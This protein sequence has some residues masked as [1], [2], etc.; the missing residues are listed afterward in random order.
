VNEH[1]IGGSLTAKSG[2][3]RGKAGVASTAHPLA[4][5]AALDVLAKGGNAVDAAIAAHAVICVVMPHAAGL[6]GDLLMLV[7]E[8]AGGL[9]AVNGTGS[10]GS[11]WSPP[12][13]GPG[14]SVTVPGIAAG[15]FAAHSRG[16]SLP[17]RQILEAAHRIAIDGYVV[18][19]SLAQARD[20]QRQRFES[21]GCQSWS[22][23][24][25]SVGQLWKQPELGDLFDNLRNH[26]AMNFYEADV[27]EAVARA[28]APFGGN[29]TAADFQDHTCVTQDAVSTKWGTG[30]I[31]VQPPAS[32]GLLLAMAARWVESHSE[33]FSKPGITGDPSTNAASDHLLVEVTGAVFAHRDDVVLCATSLL[34]EELV[35]DTVTASHRGGPRSYL[36]TAGVAVTDASGMTVS[37]LVSVFDDFGAAIHVPELGIVLNNRADG[38]TTGSNSY[39]PNTYPIHTLAPAIV[40][41]NTGHSLALATPGADG[42][43]QTLIQVLTRMRFEHHSLVDAI[44]APRWRSENGA[45]LVEESH[46]HLSGLQSRGHLV[47]PRPFGEDIFGA[48]VATGVDADGLFAAEDPRRGVVAGAI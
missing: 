43:I 22:L 45:L 24:G 16:G 17:L 38:F 18:D 10:S 36:H 14:A 27:A 4:T 42:Q 39:A 35:V 20:A 46:P 44:R 33:L 34:D 19:S 6:G 7:R 26:G 23:M 25:A 1:S 2:L 3:V 47:R 21:H 37:S 13:D 48:I 32:Q 15:W 5:R 28:V 29:L 41:D 30:V 31:S 40:V 8:S 12:T 11:H 9:Y